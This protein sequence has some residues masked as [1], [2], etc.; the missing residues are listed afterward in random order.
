MQLFGRTFFNSNTPQATVLET[1]KE[2]Y[3]TLD[4]FS[5]NDNSVG[6]N[7]YLETYL[8]SKYVYFGKNNQYPNF[9]NNLY[10]SSGL[11]SSIVDFKN[12][13]ICGNGYTLDIKGADTMKQIAIKQFFE[14]FDDD[15]SLDDRLSELVMDY[16]LHGTIYFKVFWNSDKTRVLKLKRIEPSKIRVGVDKKDV[17]TI[18]KYYY[19]FD[20]SNYGQYGITE[21]PPFTTDKTKDKVEIFRFAIPNS[22]VNFYTLPTY[23]AGAE[24]IALDGQ[25]ATFHKSNIENSIN[26]SVAIKFYQKPANNE[27]KRMILNDIKK[28]FS[29]SQNAGRA[30][31][32]FSD[33]KENAPDVTPIE[34]SNLDKQFNVTADAIQRNIC[35]A[36]KINPMIMGLKT[37]GSLGGSTELETAYNIFKDVVIK[38]AQAD[39]ERVINKFIFINQLPVT[40]KLN[41]V[42]LLLPTVAK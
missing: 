10:N 23:A 30:M 3:Q 25:V 33:G 22:A 29:G 17:S 8:G 39:I 37:P 12:S 32:F 41:T 40:F 19:C 1:K 16:I 15:K 6:L 24:W 28:N 42:D 20:W 14:H 21:F 26:P 35:Y 18:N 9:L 2:G 34:V 31:V 11:H 27:D 5:S 36:H 7:S 13:M 4:T 38:P